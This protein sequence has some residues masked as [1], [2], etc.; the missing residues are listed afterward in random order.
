[1][2]RLTGTGAGSL[3]DAYASIYE[4]Y[5]KK[6]EEKKGEDC[7][8]ASEKTEHN[9]AKKVCHEEFGEGTCVYGQHAVPDRHGFVSHYD[10]QFSHGIEKGVPV[11]EMKVLEEGSHPTAEGHEGMYD[12][13]QLDEV[14]KGFDGKP[15]PV[16]DAVRKK[17]A[18][19][20]A[21]AAKASEYKKRTGGSDY[22]AFLQGGGEAALKD[23]VAKS[24]PFA[25]KR[26]G[27]RVEVP[28]NTQMIARNIERSGRS[29]ANTPQARAAAATP[30]EKR[31]AAE[32]IFKLEPGS[33][34]ASDAKPKPKPRPKPS[35]VV[36]AKKGGVEG[37][38]DKATGKFTASNFSDA[39]RSRYV[40]RGGSSSSSTQPAKPAAKPAPVAAKPAPVAA[41][42]EPVA[43]K[44]PSISSD[45]DDLKKM[46][47]ASQIRQQTGA[48]NVTSDMIGD[49]SVKAPAPKPQMS[50]RAQALKAGGPKLGPRERMLNQDLDLFD[51]VKGH[52]IDE[53]ASEKEAM[54]L[55]VSMTQEEIL[56]FAEGYD[57][58]KMHA[59][60][61]RVMQTQGR[62]K[63]MAASAL[64]SKYSMR[65]KGNIA[66]E[67]D[68]PGPNAPKR[69]GR[70]G[71][72]AETDRGSGNKA[73]RRMDK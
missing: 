70:K 2:S 40:S 49:K 14:L 11:S 8:A 57:E 38:L 65:S 64:H 46:R 5:G 21:Y 52:L 12:G 53:G 18:N 4:G 41:K 54:K 51:L 15:L 42:P 34:S 9:C 17:V 10:V 61:K 66:G 71:R 30:E 23:R 25:V 7:T 3:A 36:L 72:G 24:T 50:A 59:A 6:K 31:A 67:T 35:Q 44:R 29:A 55:M 32:K 37:K 1:M 69:S 45:L 39:E 73:K 13:E 60:A 63:G 48:P 56:A 19:D 68:G 47:Q 26:D 58:P 43:A 62:P 33:L 16:S 27:T 28:G 20:Q 22:T